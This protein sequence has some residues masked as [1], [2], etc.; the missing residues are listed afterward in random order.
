MALDRLRAQVAAEGVLYAGDDVTDENAFA[1]LR[2][3]DV[4]VKVGEGETLA[5][6]RLPDPAAVQQLLRHLVAL[7]R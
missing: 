6:Y 7:A 1:V 5:A 4:G 3:G 2:P